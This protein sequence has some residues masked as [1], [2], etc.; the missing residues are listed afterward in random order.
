MKLYVSLKSEIVMKYIHPSLYNRIIENVPITCIDVVIVHNGQ[1]LLVIRKDSPAKGE[2][3]LPGG[4]LYKFEMLKA[5]AKRKAKEEVGLDCNVG[6]IIHTAE[7][8]FTD[9]PNGVPIHSINVVYLLQSLTNTC[10]LD[11]HHEN[12]K[13]VTHVPNE[14]HPYVEQ[15]LINA[16]FE[17]E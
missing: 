9:G 4:R 12:Y 14:L 1:A 5:A 8:V 17:N 11:S 6:P 10:R 15:S 16:G 2:W 13:W 7:T 3:W